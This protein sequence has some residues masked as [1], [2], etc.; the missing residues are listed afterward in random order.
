MSTKYRFHKPEAAYFISFATVNWVDIFT[1]EIYFEILIDSIKYCRKNK[2]LELFC[3]C[4]MPNH[5][6]MIC[7]LPIN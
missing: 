6:H 7:Q 2:G 5:V 4:I 1:R 3:Y